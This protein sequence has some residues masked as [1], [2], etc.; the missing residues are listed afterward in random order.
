MQEFI[1]EI[2]I[3]IYLRCVGK[4]TPRS[5][6]YS[7]LKNGIV[8]YDENGAVVVRILC[9]AE[10][11]ESLKHTFA[12]RPDFRAKIRCWPDGFSVENPRMESSSRL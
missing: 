7:L 2:P 1:V 3:A 9:G 12:I 4:F 5:P 10:T 11:L 8:V 6:Q